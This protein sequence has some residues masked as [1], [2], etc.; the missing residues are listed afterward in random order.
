MN[1]REPHAMLAAG[2]ERSVW[3][4]RLLDECRRAERWG[5]S[6][7]LILFAVEDGAAELA[8]ETLDLVGD[9]L[10]SG[11]RQT[12]VVL[13][14][15]PTL[16]AVLLIGAA[17]EFGQSVGERLASHVRADAGSL[18][19]GL[20]ERSLRFGAGTFDGSG[21]VKNTIAAAMRDLLI[22]LAGS[23]ITLAA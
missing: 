23:E 20:A 22:G 11:V 17:P 3:E 18:V 5:Q 16:H 4:R 7:V 6:F 2:P 13:R 21:S 9:S 10:R 19:R 1:E 14:A 8:A 15:G 12:D